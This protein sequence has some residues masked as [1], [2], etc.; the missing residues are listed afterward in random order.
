MYLNIDILIHPVWS[1]W[2]SQH[3]Q[4]RWLTR[5]IQRTEHSKLKTY[6]SESYKVRA[7]KLAHG[8][9]FSGNGTSLQESSLIGV[10][11]DMLNPSSQKFDNWREVLSTAKLIGDSMPKVFRMW[12]RGHLLLAC[13][14]I[15][16]SQM[17]SRHPPW[18]TLFVQTDEA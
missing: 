8:V 12:L 17:A 3:S 10:T 7:Y 1:G 5:R 14:K 18:S 13:A 2:G 16:D 9:K 6:D 4:V 15:P 11:Q